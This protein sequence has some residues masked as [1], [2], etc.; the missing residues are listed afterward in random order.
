MKKTL[1]LL[2]GVICTVNLSAQLI[3]TDPVFPRASDEVTVFFNAKE[4]DAGLE[5]CNCD[6]YGH[7]GIITQE[8]TNPSDWQNVPTTWG[9]ANA[10]WLLTP[11]PGQDQVYSFTFSPS[12]NDY[13][14]VEMS[15]EVL[16]LAFV[17][18]NGDGSQTG[19]SDGGQD[20]FYPVYPEDLPLTAIFVNPSQSET[21]LELGETI[22]IRGA[23]SET[24]DMTLIED[25]LPLTMVNGTTIEYDLNVTEPGTHVVELFVDNGSETDVV[26]FTYAVPLDIP[27]QDLPAGAELGF[28]LVGDTSLILALYAPN[29]ENVFVLTNINDWALTTDLQMTPT[30]DGTTWW[31]Q[32][33]GL[34]PGQNY[35]YQYLVDGNLKIADPYSTL[36]L[37]PNADGEIDDL[38]FPDLP[39]YPV[40][41]SGFLT[42]LR[43]G[44]AEYEWQVD[45]FERPEQTELVVYELLVRDFI[46]THNYQTM[47]DTLDYLENL[48]VT[49]IELMPVQE[50]ENNNSWGYNPS[51][52]MALDKYYG[53]PNK[54]KEF[55]DACHARGIAVI[56]DVVYN[57]A[58]GQSP[59]VQLYFENGAPSPES[60]WFN[61]SPTHP[62]NVGFDF[63]HE[64]QVTRDFVK[65]TITYWL[66][67][68]RLDGF[69]F[70]LSKGFTQTPNPDNV[71][72]WG[73]YDESRITILKDYADHVW[74]VTPGAYVILEH[75]AAN[76]E[77]HELSNYG[78][79][80]WGNNHFNFE[81]AV[82]GNSASLNNVS[83]KA[84]GFN[85]P[86]VVQYMESHD[87]ERLMYSA[88]ESG[89]QINQF[90][91]VRDLNVAL[92]RVELASA[93][94]Y[95][96]PGP[97]MLWQFGEHGYDVSINFNGRTGPKPIRWFYLDEA[98]R[99]RLR[100]VTSSL[101]N[102]RKNHDVFHTDD[103]SIAINNVGSEAKAK[104][105][106]LNGTDMN[107]ITIGNFDVFD[108][109]MIVN[110][111]ST[112]VWYE[113]FSGE[114]LTVDELQQVFELTP[115]E[116]RL[117][118]DVQL[119]EPVGGYIQTTGVKELVAELSAFSLRPNPATDWVQVHFTLR[120]SSEVNLQLVNQAGQ[121]IFAQHY[122]Q[123]LSGNHQLDLGTVV[124]PGVYYLHLQTA[125]GTE[126]RKLV[127]LE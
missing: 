30:P 126:T 51:F 53:T 83:Y 107:V 15:Q 34:E 17:F 35:F 115:S 60:P 13:F 63:N 101:M 40:E 4:G 76:S 46:E 22:T 93:I 74:D 67:E 8:S 100:N 92:R 96:V 82:K 11:V 62:F 71:G 118:T 7:F 110:F 38:T 58:F 79:M 45:D 54:F 52:H 21:I 32:L 120:E 9:E 88:L 29:K 95:T 108:N 64:A 23:A 109:Q 106:N 105:V 56:V 116:Y 125:S 42:W 124:G 81:N 41:A 16:E 12:I 10:D 26:S 18:R 49:A 99:N 31:T 47:I 2:L 94:F 48:G 123:L 50:F 61:E 55:V 14:N 44:A 91:D 87:E 103:F 43:P 33:D 65:R 122:G 117:Y 3:S 119:E 72:A 39:D 20:I 86:H 85:D 84:R 113:Y 70:D 90:H 97:K 19:K 1:L 80:L 69:R 6:V 121:Q 59:L 102:L 75:F 89:Q 127:V 112:G 78:M 73:Q 98:D 25:G 77:E 114:T 36:I 28:N 66:E 68:F 5:N 27:A 24:A 37:D 111:P 57:H 104:R